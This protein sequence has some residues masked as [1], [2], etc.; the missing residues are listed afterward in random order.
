MQETIM[1]ELHNEPNSSK[2]T[3]YSQP[4]NHSRSSQAGFSI[5][6]TINIAINKIECN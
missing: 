3:G 1:N 5:E 2:G 6:V 4:E